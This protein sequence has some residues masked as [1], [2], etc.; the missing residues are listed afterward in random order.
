MVPK[1]AVVHISNAFPYDERD[2]IY[3]VHYDEM[4]VPVTV[5][6]VTRTAHHDQWAE[7]RLPLSRC[8]LHSLYRDRNPLPVHGGPHSDQHL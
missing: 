6:P 4:K 3:P 7:S 2:K 8:E 5:S 1:I